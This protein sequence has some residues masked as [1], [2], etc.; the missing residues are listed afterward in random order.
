MNLISEKLKIDTALTS[1]NLNGAGTSDYYALNKYGRGLFVVEIGA[2]AAAATSVLQV[3]QATDA[4]G[5]GPAKAVTNLVAT[6][7][8]NFDV[9]AA[10]LTVAAVQVADVVTVNG[11]VFTGAAAADLPN[12]VFLADVGDD[13]ATATSLAAAINHA[14]GVPGVTATANAAVVTLVATEP[15]EADITIENAS[16]TITPATLRAVGYV[17]VDA[18]MLDLA[19]GFDHVAIQVTNSAAMLTGAVLLR[20]DARYTPTQYV[21]AS[22]TDTSA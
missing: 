8:A 12:N 4:A 21:A 9:A 3:M 11:V 10:T 5:G 17:E 22:K 19:N 15:G 7:T 6:M 2:M 20:G 16:A 18:S 1:Q 14:N 13:G